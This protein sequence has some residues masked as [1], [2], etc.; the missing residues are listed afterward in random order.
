MTRAHVLAKAVDVIPDPIYYWRER[1]KGELSI[2]QS[3]TEHQQLQGPDHRAAGHRRVPAR[4]RL[5][6]AAPRA[7]A[8]GAGQ[9]PVAVRRRPVPDQ[10][11]VPGRVHRARRQVPRPGRPAGDREA[12]V[13]AQARL[14]PDQTRASSSSSGSSTPG[15]P[16][17]RSRPRRWS[18][19]LGRL[20]ADL[21]FRGDRE[22]EDPG[23]R[24]PAVLAGARPVRPRRGP[25]LARRHRLVITG[26]AFVP[27]VDITKRRHASKIVIL[28]PRG[29]R[30][31][32]IVIP[33]RSL[34]HPDATR[35]SGQDRYSYDWAGLPLR[36]QLPLV[37]GRPPLADRPVGLLH[38]GQGARGAGVPPGCTRRSA[39]PPSGRSSCEVAPRIRFGARWVG[40]R[41]AGGGDQD[42]RGAA[43]VRARRRASCGS[44]WTSTGWPR[45]RQAGAGAGPAEGRGHAAPPGHRA[46]DGRRRRLRGARARYRCA[47]WRRPQRRAGRRRAARNGTC[48]S[49]PAARSGCG[50]RS[51]PGRPST[52]TRP[53][54]RRSR[55]SGPGTATR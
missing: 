35:W 10:R 52:S 36:D 13:H 4:A 3:R 22:P 29:R 55:S 46:P 15:R 2:T 30:R 47:S 19:E 16:G 23:Q 11:R 43:R 53:A 18:G 20:W 26:C 31:L 44:T 17:S 45:P 33:A 25:R 39:A 37:P 34:R 49:R 6:Q 9:R 51:R 12:A 38:A 41:A 28:R 27:S 24:L 1:G 40:Q 14:P 50:W 42:A 21:P 32:P 54:T 8:Q 7:P 48:T 5:G